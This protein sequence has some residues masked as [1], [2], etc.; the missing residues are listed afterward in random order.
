MNYSKLKPQR[1]VKSKRL[2]RDLTMAAVPVWLI[3]SLLCS[4]CHVFPRLL[5][6][7]GSQREGIVQPLP[8]HHLC[9]WPID[10]WL[11]VIFSHRER[12]KL[13]S[14]KL[15]TVKSPKSKLHVAK[16][17]PSLSPHDGRQTKKFPFCHFWGTVDLAFPANCT[18]N[19]TA[20]L[21]GAA[22]RALNEGWY[23]AGRP[24]SRMAHSLHWKQRACEKIDKP[25]LNKSW[26]TASDLGEGEILCS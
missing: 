3:H 10:N 15:R 7:L 18:E 17:P 25:Y 8:F 22:Q 1:Q 19:M 9:N 24:F 20:S 2:M 16:I 4:S 13:P 12:E 21:N 5:N 23:Q 6:T 14:L 26:D 11:M